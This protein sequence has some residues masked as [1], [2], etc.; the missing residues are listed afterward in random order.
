[1][2]PSSLLILLPV[3][4]TTTGGSSFS[5]TRLD[6]VGRRVYNLSA[7]FI[8]LS[9]DQ[10]EFNPPATPT[11]S[12][13]KGSTLSGCLL[14]RP[15]IGGTNK[16]RERITNA[17]GKC[18][19]ICNWL[20]LL[21]NKSLQ[22]CP[23]SCDFLRASPKFGALQ[24]QAKQIDDRHNFRFPKSNVLTS[25]QGKEEQQQQLDKVSDATSGRPTL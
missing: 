20:S 15:E 23:R 17:L 6:R 8:L 21:L 24:L 19:T 5:K 16:T 7:L 11:W 9:F 18:P 12:P 13:T 14:H 10:I 22:I 1:M 2:P 3:S 4:L 25:L